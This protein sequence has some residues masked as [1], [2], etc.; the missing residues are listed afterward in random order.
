MNADRLLTEA[1]A[2]NYINMSRQFLRKSRM[3]GTL[4]NHTQGPPFIR[5]GR[6]IRYNLDDLDAWID[7]RRCVIPGVLRAVC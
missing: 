6:S 1:E 4:P 2:S 5:I 3:N 7:E